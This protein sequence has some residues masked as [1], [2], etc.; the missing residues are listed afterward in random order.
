MAE[1]SSRP[2]LDTNLFSPKKEGTTMYVLP[3]T[4]MARGMTFEIGGVAGQGR[5]DDVRVAVS[6]ANQLEKQPPH[7][8]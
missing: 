1:T 4:P 3:E 8:S 2:D 7:G 6:A 5:L